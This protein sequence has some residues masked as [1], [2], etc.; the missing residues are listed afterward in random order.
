MAASV[1][2]ISLS[3]VVPAALAASSTSVLVRT[4]RAAA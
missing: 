3:G 2:S 4:D 1:S